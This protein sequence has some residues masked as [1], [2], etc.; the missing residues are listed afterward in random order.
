MLILGEVDEWQSHPPE[1][2]QVMLD[3]I[4]ELRASGRDVIED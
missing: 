3:S 4:A 1:A 2:P